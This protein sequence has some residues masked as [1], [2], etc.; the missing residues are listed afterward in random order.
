MKV[1]QKKIYNSNH[2]LEIL[3]KMTTFFNIFD[4]MVRT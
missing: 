1:P 2:F 3:Q 4:T